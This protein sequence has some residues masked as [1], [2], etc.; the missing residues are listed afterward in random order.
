MQE[1]VSTRLQQV[2]VMDPNPHSSTGNN[3]RPIRPRWE[4]F[5]KF[6]DDEGE[7]TWISFKYERLPVFCEKCGL[8]AHK[9]SRCNL[10]EEQGKYCEFGQWLRAESKLTAMS[11]GNITQNKGVAEESGEKEV[12]SDEDNSEDGGVQTG[13]VGESKEVGPHAGAEPGPFYTG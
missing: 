1:T 3:E 12:I 13:E 6:E 10:S 8:L 2:S 9:T 5:Y 7:P 4:F 11:G